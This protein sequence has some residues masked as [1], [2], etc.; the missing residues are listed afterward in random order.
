MNSS[1]KFIKG[2]KTIRTK[3]FGVP[4]QTVYKLAA[5]VP[6]RQMHEYFWIGAFKLTRSGWTA[7]VLKGERVLL[8]QL[9]SLPFFF[10]CINVHLQRKVGGG[11]GAGHC[12][13]CPRW[14]SL[15]IHTIC[16]LKQT[17]KSLRERAR[18]SFSLRKWF[19]FWRR[20]MLHLYVYLFSKNWGHFYQRHIWWN[21]SPESL[22]CESS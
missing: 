8:L 18:S 21:S 9:R 19:G 14:F 10:F 6:Q 12:L 3:A 20:R 11:G 5:I 4:G 7:A 1:K 17:L 16:V 13:S 15:G 2:L 22:S